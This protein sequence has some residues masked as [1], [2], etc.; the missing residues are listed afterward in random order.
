LHVR[1]AIFE[2]VAVWARPVGSGHLG[3]VRVL[4]D[5]LEQLGRQPIAGVHRLD[6]GL[7]LPTQGE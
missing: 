1:V 2:R 6:R 4:L 7:A 5:E 3:G